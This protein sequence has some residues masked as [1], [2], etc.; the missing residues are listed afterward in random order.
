MFFHN[1]DPILHKLHYLPAKVKTIIGPLS[2]LYYKLNHPELESTYNFRIFSGVRTNFISLIT[3]SWNCPG[4]QNCIFEIVVP[5]LADSIMP[6]LIACRVGI[7]NVGRDTRALPNSVI[8]FYA[9][10]Q[11]PIYTNTSTLHYIGFSVTAVGWQKIKRTQKPKIINSEHI[12]KL[13]RGT[14][15]ILY[16][17]IIYTCTLCWVRSRLIGRKLH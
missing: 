15:T 16:C 6:F 7:S 4:R 14:L 17:L 11:S 2:A 5:A 13:P 9:S 12:N 10:S 8:I 1:A 3:I